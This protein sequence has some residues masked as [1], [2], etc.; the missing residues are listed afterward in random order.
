MGAD[1]EVDADGGARAASRSATSR[2]R[3]ARAHGDDDRGR[4]DPER[5]DE[6]PALAVAA[7][8]A[9]GVTEIRDAAELAVKESNRI[10]TLHQELTQLGIAVEPRA[11]GLVDPRRRAPR[12][13]LLKSHGD[14]R[15]AM[16]AAVAANA[17][18][19]E[20]TVRGLAR[21]SASSY[22]EFADDLAT[23]DRSVGMTRPMRRRRDRRAV[24]LG[25]VDGRARRR[26]RAR[27]RRCS[28]PARCTARS[29][30][31]RSSTASPLD[32]DDACARDR[33][34]A[35]TIEVEDGVTTLDGR[36]VSAEI[37]GPEVTAAVSTVSAHP[38]VRTVLVD[39]PARVGRR[40]RRR[41]GR[42]PRHRHRRVPDAPVKVFL[43]A[44]D[45]E[46][47]RRRQRDE[48]AA[49]RTVDGRRRAGRAR[50]ARR[51]RQRPGGVAAA[52]RP[53]TRS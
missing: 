33:R 46:R 10:G 19:G 47:A 51:A 44:S 12:P 21:R 13:A 3:A 11:D 4:R 37:R 34:R 27:A 53:T 36:D 41:S 8:F 6:V 31:P 22:P 30:S 43:T 15:I 7:A 42:R 5:Q 24:G 45:D 32:D 48:A 17:I 52:A 9:D 2:V 25:E 20:S 29:R 40:A 1:I 49:D 50:A 14:H 39:A 26:R 28:T 35:S 16:A 38:A 18:D 23:A